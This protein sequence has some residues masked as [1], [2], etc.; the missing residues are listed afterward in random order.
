MK[1]L[2]SFDFFLKKQTGDLCLH[3][4]SRMPNKHTQHEQFD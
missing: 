4:N 1:G 3:L 2:I